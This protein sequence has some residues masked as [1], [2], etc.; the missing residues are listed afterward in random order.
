MGFLTV[1]HWRLW[2]ED[3]HRAGDVMSLALPHTLLD[4]A[5][6]N[7]EIV[8]AA[9]AAFRTCSHVCPTPAGLPA[10]PFSSPLPP[11]F[12]KLLRLS[13]GLSLS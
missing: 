10:R 3:F 5:Q 12:P 6:C 8:C 1:L 2:G 7:S 4:G 11:F 9:L 13:T